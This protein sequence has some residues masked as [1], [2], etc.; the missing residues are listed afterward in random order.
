V[1]LPG[2][3]GGA[4]SFLLLEDDVDQAS[5]NLKYTVLP[6]VMQE[7]SREWAGAR[8]GGGGGGLACFCSSKM[9]S[10]KGR[11]HLAMRSLEERSSAPAPRRMVSDSYCSRLSAEALS[12]VNSMLS[13]LYQ[14]AATSPWLLLSSRILHQACRI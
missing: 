7:P 13:C 1:R 11:C 4:C 12:A 5:H 14:L 8:G 3:G 10:A 2:E 9:M 6:H